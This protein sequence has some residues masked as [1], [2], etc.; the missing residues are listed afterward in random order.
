MPGYLFVGNVVIGG[1]EN[2][3][4]G[5]AYPATAADVGFVSYNDGDG[6]DYHLTAN[7]AYKAYGTD[8]KAPGADVDAVLGA[9]AG[10]D[11]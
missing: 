1:G 4:A 9:T 11:Q 3:V 5:N 6:G 7:S 10:V 2:R 8:G